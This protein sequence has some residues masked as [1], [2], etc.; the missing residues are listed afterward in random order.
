MERLAD[1]AVVYVLDE[2][3]D[4]VRQAALAHRDPS[5]VAGAEELQRRY[6]PR[7]QPD[8]PFWKAM[9]AGAPQL[10]YDIPDSV[11][12]Q[13]AESPEHLELLRTLEVKSVLY[14]PIQARGRTLG[15]L[16]MMTTAASYRQL[17]RD[18][19]A[20]AEEIGR[21]AGLAL[22]NA[23][24]FAQSQAAI[25]ARDEF[26]SIASHELRNP[27]ASISGVAQLLEREY[28]RGQL[29]PE[30][31]Q[32]YIGSLGRTATRLADLTEDLLDVSRLRQGRLPLRPE[33]TDISNL[34]REVIARSQAAGDEVTFNTT[35]ESDPCPVM[36]DADRVSQ[37]LSNLVGNAVK[38]NLAGAPIDIRL[39]NNHEGVLLSVCDRGI[40]LPAGTNEMIFE[41]FGRAPNAAA[42]NIPGLGLGLYI[43]RQIAER[44]GGRLW[45]ES[46]GEGKG[47]TFRLWLPRSGPAPDVDS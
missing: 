45:A 9:Y 40:G 30:R 3:A 16:V 8:T 13:S 21:R 26:L 14:A 5:R 35:M 42:R 32:R 38:Y 2:E 39:E 18:D 17:S 43:S 19:L 34:V 37:V 4:T 27:V 31:V 29:D 6:P 41:P 15:V 23:R 7:R 22:D 10:V 46:P 44:H 11:L 28:A 36:A 24:L 47:T 20:V 12:V 1:W 33:Q 25:R